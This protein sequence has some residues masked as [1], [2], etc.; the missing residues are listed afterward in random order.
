MCVVKGEAEAPILRG[1]P[2][3]A[4]LPRAMQEHDRKTMGV[5][6]FLIRHIGMVAMEGL[7]I[8][9]HRIVGTVLTWGM[10]DGA[11]HEEAALFGDGQGRRMV[12]HGG[13]VF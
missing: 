4:R 7:T 10:D 9:R 6:W 13:L 3:L 5:Q 11:T 1:L 2:S 8:V 12:R